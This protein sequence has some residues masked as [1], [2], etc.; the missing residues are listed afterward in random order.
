MNTI[1]NPVSNFYSSYSFDA[2]LPII[3][4][5]NYIDLLSKL[6]SI[7]QSCILIN[8]N[9]VNVSFNI[10]LKFYFPSSINVI[11][12]LNITLINTARITIVGSNYSVS[13]ITISGGSETHT[14]N[15]SNFLNVNNTKNVSLINSSFINIRCA[16][17]ILD[18]VR[19]QKSASNFKMYNCLFNGKFCNGV[20]LNLDFPLNYLIKNCVFLNFVNPNITNG[21]ETIRMATSPYQY[22]NAYA[23]IDSCYFSNCSGDPELISVKCSSNT[24]KNCVFNNIPGSYGNLC[25]RLTNSDNVNNCYFTGYS[26]GMRVYGLNHTI[27]NIQLDTGSSIL[28]DNKTGNYTPAQN[29]KLTDIS[30]NNVNNPVVNKG[31]NCSV[32]NLVKQIK[33]TSQS[34]FTAQATPIG[35]IQYSAYNG[36]TSYGNWKAINIIGYS[37]YK[38]SNNI[39]LPSPYNVMSQEQKNDMINMYQSEVYGNNL[40]FN[41]P[42]NGVSSGTIRLHFSENYSGNNAAGKRVFNINVAGNIV[43]NFDIF[44]TAGA[45]YTGIYID[46]VVNNINSNISVILSAVKDYAKIDGIEFFPFL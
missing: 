7:T 21:G 20:F 27:S 34:L 15:G 31:I 11:V 33:F 41:V 38:V 22:S 32:T 44:K 17:A 12:V 39:T 14:F 3:Y 5:N 2:S 6:S 29:C 25:L 42:S 45:L 40:S 37:I 16:D 23:T 13:N 46:F 35:T 4:Y 10:N 1:I 43:N 28:L 26:G 9:P 19:I 18:F 24:I 30:Y 36:A 8:T